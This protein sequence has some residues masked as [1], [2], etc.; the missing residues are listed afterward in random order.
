VLFRRTIQLS[1]SSKHWAEVTYVFIVL[2]GRW[3]DGSAA[4]VVEEHFI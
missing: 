4:S 3:S 1:V 2:V